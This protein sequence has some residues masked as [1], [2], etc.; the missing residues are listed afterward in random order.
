MDLS[1]IVD[2]GGN[3][4]TAVGGASLLAAMLPRPEKGSRLDGVFKLLDLL[5]ANWANARNKR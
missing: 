3:V 2:V 5:A 1:T 4:L